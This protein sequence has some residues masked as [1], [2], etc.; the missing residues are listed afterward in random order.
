MCVLCRNGY[1]NVVVGGVDVGFAAGV[2]RVTHLPK[3][4]RLAGDI[5]TPLDRSDGFGVFVASDVRLYSEGLALM[6]AADGRLRVSHVASS[7]ERAAVLI[8]ASDAD[9]MLVD[10][11]MRGARDVLRAARATAMPVVIFGV[12][13][14][15][16]DLVDYI[17]AGA[18]AFVSRDS[19]SND[20]ILTVLSAV[21]GE[22][23]LTCGSTATIV[24][25]LTNRARLG[26]HG[27]ASS[28]ATSPLTGRERELALLL[29]EGLS[30]KE[31]AR[32][33]SISV[34]TVKNHVHRILEKLHVERR[35]QAAARLR[36]PMNPRI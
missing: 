4:E 29:D 34:A 11:S 32:R 3:Q 14:L 24:E 8:P 36:E 5:G 13:E 33:L 28:V 30:N 35:G 12:P 18:A 20:L 16:E 10:A 26:M 9:A 19:S 2:A 21:R 17:D 6:F 22:A 27:V 15:D 7:A 31:I 23:T 25:R 1:D